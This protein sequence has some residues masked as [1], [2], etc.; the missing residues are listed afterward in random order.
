[1]AVAAQADRHAAAVPVL[2]EI[3]DAVRDAFGEPH[4]ARDV[5]TAMTAGLDQ[6]PRDLAAVLDD[7]DDRAEALGEPGLQSRVRQN[8]AQ[9]LRQAAVDILKSCLKARSSVR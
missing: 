5:G 6:F 3:L 7:V 8:E 2:V 4:L 1:M 9:R